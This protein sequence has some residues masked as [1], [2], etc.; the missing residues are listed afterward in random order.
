MSIGRTRPGNTGLTPIGPVVHCTSVI[1]SALPRA[2]ASKAIMPLAPLRFSTTMRWPSRF[3]TASEKRRATVSPMPPG[4]KPTTTFKGP[5][6][7]KAGSVACAA[8]L[9]PTV[10]IAAATMLR[11]IPFPHL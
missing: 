8:G 3:W 2:I 7:T 9:N 6:G 1:P 4:W 10:R 11:F 5:S